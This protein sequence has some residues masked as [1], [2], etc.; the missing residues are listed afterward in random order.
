MRRRDNEQLVDR[1]VQLL[2]LAGGLVGGTICVHRQ[3]VSADFFVM[4]VPAIAGL[5]E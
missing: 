4:R 3:K 2:G 5:P 1:I